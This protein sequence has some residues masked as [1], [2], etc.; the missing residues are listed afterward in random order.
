MSRRRRNQRPS[1]N[2]RVQSPPTQSILVAAE[3][4]IESQLAPEARDNYLKIVIAGMKAAL[5]DGQNS[6]LAGLKTSKDPVADCAKGAL[7]LVLI[8]KHQAKGVMPENAMI[9]AASTLMI[10]ALSFAD[11]MGVVKVGNPELVRATHI[12]TNEILRGMKMTPQKLSHALTKTHALMQ[13]PIAMEQMKR[14]AGTVQ[15]PMQSKPTLPPEG[16]V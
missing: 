3:E 14:A 9:P 4:K 12:F 8:L 7:S 5:D 16:N 2:G 11:R 6:F 13:D 15:H 10:K 1:L